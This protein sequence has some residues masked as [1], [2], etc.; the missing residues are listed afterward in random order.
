MAALSTD[1]RQRLASAWGRLRWEVQRLGRGFLR[2]QGWLGVCIVAGVLLLAAAWRF[3]REQ[4]AAFHA[5]R[6][7]GAAHADTVAL[8]LEAEL[9]DSRQ[10]MQRF[11]SH[12]L[13]HD[14]LPT[15]VQ[16]LLNL[17]EDEH[18]SARRGEYRPH[19]DTQGGF[20]RYRIS[21]PVSGDARAVHR[22]IETALRTHPALGLESVQFQRQ[23]I[24]STELEARIQ[25]VVL[26]R[27]PQGHEETGRIS[28]DLR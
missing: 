28:G 18:L 4:A 6:F 24:D 1:L 19:V 3:E 16:D 21:L 20:L 27:L 7:H 22:F 11:E 10:R 23:R 17:A 9:P 14:E 12:L 26:A 13:A 2:R 25:W 8:A 5:Q 15:Q